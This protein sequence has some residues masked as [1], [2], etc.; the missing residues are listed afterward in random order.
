MVFSHPKEFRLLFRFFLNWDKICT[1]FLPPGNSLL[2]LTVFRSKWAVPEGWGLGQGSGQTQQ[3]RGMRA[4][5]QNEGLNHWCHP[6]GIISQEQLRWKSKE[7]PLLWENFLPAWLL[8]WKM[9]LNE[10]SLTSLPPLFYSRIWKNIYL[11]ISWVAQ[12]VKNLPEVRE[13]W[14]QSLGC[15]WRRKWQPSPVFWLGEFHAQRSLVGYSPWGRRELDTT[16]R[17]TLSLFHYDVWE[18]HW[19]AFTD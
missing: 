3:L 7:L 4:S 18:R 12:M 17:L 2:T 9:Y 15:P 19:E 16:E 8:N 14:V 6:L 1:P 5:F 10:F 13:T 11:R